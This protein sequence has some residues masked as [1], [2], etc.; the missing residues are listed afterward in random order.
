M[1]KIT[2]I[3]LFLSYW[4]TL[5][6]QEKVVLYNANIVDV[7]SGK[8]VPSKTITLENGIITKISNAKKKIRTG[9]VDVTGKYIL[10]GLIDSHLHWANFAEDRPAMDSLCSVYLKDGVTTV[11]DVGGDA[12]VLKKYNSYR[13]KDG[14]V[15]PDVYY[16]SFWAGK[17]YFDLR[18]RDED[19]TTAWNLEIN[20][21]DNYEKAIINAK[22]VGCLGLKLYADITFEQLK[23]I[24]ALCHKH[25]VKPWGH[26]ASNED[27]ALEVVRAGVEVVSH[28]YYVNSMLKASKGTQEE[29][30]SEM[31][32][33]KTVLDPTLTI[34][35]ENNMDYVIEHFKTAYK[36]GVE[37]VA[38]TDYIE[39]SDDNN[40]TCFMLHEMD[41]YVDKCGVST[42]DALRSATINGAKILGKEGKLGVI[43]KGAEADILVL[44][45]NPLESIKALRNIKSI[46]LNGE[47]CNIK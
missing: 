39:I 31:I 25:G 36:A 5:S 30:Y 11:R 15:G 35:T 27:N 26:L 47:S 41:L 8:I 6:A 10:P 32:K 7:V 43:K 12:T 13:E 20:P 29:L 4:V 45:E 28:I 23:E 14:L 18:G 1:K 22:E 40:Y 34:S 33:R 24:V 38:G 46:Y 19:V 9:D 44:N 21:G 3:L 42:I 16:S 37:F 17:N 2:F